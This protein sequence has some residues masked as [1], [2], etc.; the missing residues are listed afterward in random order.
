[1]DQKIKENQKDKKTK[2]DL[3]EAHRNHAVVLLDQALLKLENMLNVQ[4]QIPDLV[5]LPSLFPTPQ[6]VD[7]AGTGFEILLQGFT[8]D[9][10]TSNNWYKTLISQAGELA[11]TGFTAIWLPPPSDS[12][13][14]QVKDVKNEE[15]KLIDLGLFAK[16]FV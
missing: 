2:N 9:S 8:W 16:R 15:F 7:A 12:V 10:S 1:L 4:E 6:E 5:T 3:F 11:Q 14:E 13:S